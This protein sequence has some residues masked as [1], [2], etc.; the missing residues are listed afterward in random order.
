MSETLQHWICQWCDFVQQSFMDET[1]KTAT[2]T[3]FT[4]AQIK[5]NSLSFPQSRILTPRSHLVF[6]I[7]VSKSS[8]VQMNVS[9]KENQQKMIT[10]FFVW[11]LL[12]P[13]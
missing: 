7:C 3:T 4:V 10:S 11:V 6:L 9:K 5:A 12:P 8:I 13:R 2:T 1:V